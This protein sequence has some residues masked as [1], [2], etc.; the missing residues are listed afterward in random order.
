[1][2]EKATMLHIEDDEAD[3]VLFQRD[4]QRLG[5]RGRYVRLSSFDEAKDFLASCSH[6]DGA[7]PDLIVADSRFGIYTAVDIV[8]WVKAHHAFRHV[9]VVVYSAAISPEQRGEVMRE[10]AA[11]CLIKQIDAA[12]NLRML[13][14]ILCHLDAGRAD[15][16]SN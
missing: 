5:F 1:M 6:K 16:S 7:V 4:L 12:D 3:H 9:P 8:R 14:R 15:H 13:E 11:D 2:Y 10:G